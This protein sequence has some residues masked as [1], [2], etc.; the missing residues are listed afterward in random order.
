MLLGDV[1]ESALEKVGITKDRV[2][3]WMGRPCK[4]DVRRQKLN[5]IDH[6]ARRVLAGYTNKAKEY[7]DQIL[8][9]RL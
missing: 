6:W 3:E 9:D 4:C 8:E 1:V 7:L 2:E 5:S